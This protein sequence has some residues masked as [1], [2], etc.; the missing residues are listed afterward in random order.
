L[1]IHL[2]DG[3]RL[4]VRSKG[5][6]APTV[7]LVHGWSLSGRVWEALFDIWPESAGRLL[8]VDLRGTGWSTKPRGG[9]SLQQ[10]RDDIVQLI[11]QLKLSNLVLVGH[12]MG[13][14]IAMQVALERGAQLSRIILLATVPA[15]GVPLA[16]ADVAFFRAQGGRQEGAELILGSMMSRKPPKEL[17]D[18]LVTDVSS[19]AIE[20]FL[21]AFDAWRTASFDDQMGA[22]ATPTVVIGG[23]LDPVITPSVLQE[24]VV[25]RI[26]G[27][28]FMTLSG[29]GHYPQVEAPEELKALLL[30]EL[31]PAQ[32]Q[33]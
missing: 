29:V 14:A 25:A 27:S 22:I 32:Q 31:Q 19:V 4:H 13:G 21:E 5:E 30:R 1:D 12:S 8:A 7:L 33:S 3:N 11:D 6:G 2:S 20:A 18:R 17:F 23:E 26:A 24:K 15:S 9:Y 16:D 28:R 10:Y